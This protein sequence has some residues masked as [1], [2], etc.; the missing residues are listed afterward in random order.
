MCVCVYMYIY[1]HTQ[2]EKH[3]NKCDRL[4]RLCVLQFFV[5]IYSSSISVRQRNFLHEIIYM[6]SGGMHVH[7]YSPN[8]DVQNH[9]CSCCRQNTYRACLI[10]LSTVMC[11]DKKDRECHYAKYKQTINLLKAIMNKM[12]NFVF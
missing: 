12:N 1:K 3:I 6:D 2:M 11:L 8:H 4:S 10:L 9:S 5:H 7:N